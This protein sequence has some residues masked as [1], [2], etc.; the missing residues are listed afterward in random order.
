MM[1][2]MINQVIQ[3][4]CLEIMKKIPDNSIDLILTDLPYGIGYK[5]ID[6]DDTQE[7]LINLINKLMPQLF[8][9]SQ[10]I[11]I[12]C[13]VQNIWLY[14]KGDWIISWN[15]KG[16]NTFGKYGYNQWQPVIMYGKDIK[17][18]GS[19]NHILK[20]DSIKYEGGNCDEIKKFEN[21]PCPKNLGIMKRLINRL[22]NQNNLILD[23]FLGSGTTAVAAKELGRRFIGIEISEKYCA[24]ARQRLRQEYL[25][26]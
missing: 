19:I 8:R 26:L 1:N 25:P 2:E 5:Y 23:P 6:Y 3:G 16:T 10:R 12:F 11:A 14:P 18:F 15:W 9:V 24:T 13:G 4:D 17:G 21:H 7:N 20:S 22:S